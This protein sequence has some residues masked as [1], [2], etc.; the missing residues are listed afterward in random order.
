MKTLF[1][2]RNLIVSTFV[3]ML[4]TYSIQGISYGQ[5]A[6]DDIV[7]FADANLAK[8]VRSALNLPTR[9]GVDLLK[10][11]KTE[12]EKLTKLSTWY[13]DI[14]NLTGLEHAT[15]LKELYLGGE[16]VRDIT[17]LAQLTQLKALS[18]YNNEVKDITPLAQLTQL[19]ELN[20]SG[21]S[22]SDITPLAQLTQLTELNLNSEWGNNNVS[23]L[24]PL[25]QL[26]QLRVLNLWSNNVSDITPLAQLTQLTE[27][28]LERNNISDLTPLAHLRHL[29]TIKTN[30]FQG[31]ASEIPLIKV[32]AT[33]LLVETTLNGSSVTL[34]LLRDGTSYDVSPDNIRNAL[35]VSGINGVAVSDITRVSDTEIIAVLEFTGNF[36]TPTTLTFAIEVEAV[37]GFDA[38]ALTGTIRVYPEEVPPIIASTPQ[39]LTGATLNE[40]RVELTLSDAAFSHRATQVR[41]ALT[42]SGIPGISIGR[43]STIDYPVQPGYAGSK[44]VSI[45]LYY[46]GDIIATDTIL[47]L[48]VG[49][50]ATV[51]YKGPPLTVQIPVKGV[52][53]AELAELSQAMVASTAYP[54]TEATLNGSI[55]TLR[56]TNESYSFQSSSYSIRQHV[57]VSGIKGV[58]IAKEW[59]RS[60]TYWDFK[61]S[62]VVRKVNATEI[63]VE[64]RFSGS[65][66]KDATLIFTVESDAIVPYNGPPLT[67]E[68]SVSATT[69]VEP[70]GDLVASTPFPLTKT[71]LHGSTVV[72]TLQNRS[73]AYRADTGNDD[74]DYIEYL[75]YDDIRYVG[76]SGIHDVQTAD[77]YDSRYDNGDV[78]RLSSSEILVE[79]DFQGDFDTDVTLTFTVPAGIIENY[80]GPPLTAEL[81]VTVETELRVLS[82]ELQGQPMFWVNTQTGKIG[83]SEYFDAITNE[84][85]V[86]TVDR[87][88]EK[89]YW[90]ER[91][92]SGG[93]IKRADFDGTNVEALV[94]LSNVPR[95]IVID[96][97]ANKLYWTNSDLQIQ[98][99]TLDGEDVSTVIQLEKDILEETKKSCSAGGFFWL[100]I[101][102]ISYGGGCDTETVHV[103]LTSPTDI[104]LNAADGR[105]YWTEFSGR[106]RR[107]NVDGTGLG[108]LLSDIGSP[109][110]IT[111]AGDKIYWAEEVDENSGKIQRANLNGTNVETLAT[112]QGLPTGISIDTAA[113]KIYWANSLGGIQRTDLNGGEVE[114]VVS[115]ISSP[116]DFVLVPGAQP[117]IPTT[118]ET[119]ATTGATVSISPASVASSTVGE[120]LEL[121]LNITDGKAVAGY[122]ATVQFDTT[123][124]RYVSGANGDYLPAGAFFVEP[125]VE[126]NLVKLNAA[127]LAGES[128]GD[129]T[130]TTLTFEV[131]AAK[132]FTLTLSDVL[133]TNSTG[134]AFV[135]TVENAEIT[136]STQLKGDINGDGIINIQDLVLTASNL[137]KTGQNPADVNGDGSVNIQDLVLVAGALGT[138]AAAPSLHPHALEMLT[139][140]DVK[141]WLSTAQ[142]LDLTDTTS[143]RGILFLQ[144]LLITLTPKETVLL[145]NYPNPFNPETWIPYHLAKDANVT[146][147][148]YAVN[149]TLV[150]T[151]TLGHQPAGMYQNRSRAAYWDGKNAFG[152]PVASGVYFYTITAGDFTA[153]RKMLI[154]K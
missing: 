28:N 144:Q 64:L 105:L 8:H 30:S 113:D 116:G 103:N 140:A 65:I 118:P 124:L 80:D 139:A 137:G 120:Q 13:D 154:R 131:V 3:V 87:A 135:P 109:Y 47:T 89:L 56:L 79:I 112:V 57:K 91:S 25:A 152:E 115:G 88:G 55:V 27:L 63:A 110:G 46:D 2:N 62:N 94:T 73:Y 78:I 117:T 99:A 54:L 83:S 29:G 50:G 147:H 125:K 66:D 145:A 41:S 98:T 136:E 76:I 61:V 81:P 143:Q 1:V 15:Q 58:T 104:A 40:A 72:L 96:S 108:T 153:T 132:A 52:T 126:G 32:T 38:R 7:E 24:T 51:N 17:P 148:I 122:Q 138:S 35:R 37:S 111:V 11:P 44:K 85:T 5:D 12:L 134:E 146:L 10:I 19:T 114:V 48:T 95:G 22:I 23:D 43:W 45:I 106:I 20:L 123:A 74:G 33:Q 142:Q 92:K 84:V 70:T 90:G 39:P 107:V 141:H 59:A 93:V 149:G 21:N 121:G 71:T 9:G 69:E 130:L 68:I 119:P 60:A 100:L 26:T 53:E 67:T 151:L 6:P 42:I 101:I 86:L 150:R 16:D 18:L 31:S 129:G 82:S 75:D 127:S 4:L 128:N 97:A 102:P 34:T 133:L 49:P 14:T 77:S 36:D